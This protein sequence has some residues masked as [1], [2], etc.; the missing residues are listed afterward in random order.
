MGLFST[1]TPVQETARALDRIADREEKWSEFA[2]RVQEATKD[3]RRPL[4]DERVSKKVR[5]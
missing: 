5:W 4:L 3:A 1:R 2:E